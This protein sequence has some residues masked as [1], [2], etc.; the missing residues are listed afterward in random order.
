M[1]LWFGSKGKTNL[2]SNGYLSSQILEDH[3][4]GVSKKNG[5]NPMFTPAEVNKI[6]ILHNLNKKLWVW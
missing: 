4:V 2:S 1:K 3:N 6:W 5:S